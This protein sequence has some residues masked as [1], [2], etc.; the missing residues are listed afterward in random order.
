MARHDSGRSGSVR[1]AEA[2]VTGV[3]TRRMALDVA[4]I[5]IDSFRYAEPFRVARRAGSQLLEVA[6]GGKHVLD[7]SAG[8]PAQ[9][10]GACGCKSLKGRGLMSRTKF[11]AWLMAADGQAGGYLR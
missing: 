4:S 5:F 6:E 9:S 8:R 10:G 1:L 3:A 7:R 2:V 11:A